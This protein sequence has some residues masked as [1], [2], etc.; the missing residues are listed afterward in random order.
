[1]G[2]NPT[3]DIKLDHN[4]TFHSRNAL[5]MTE[6]ELRL[7]VARL[8]RTAWV[9]LNP[10][11]GGLLVPYDGSR[12]WET[13]PSQLILR[14]TE[15]CVVQI[16]PFVLFTIYILFRMKQES[17]ILRLLLK[18][19]SAELE[20]VQ[21]YLANAV[22]LDGLR[23]REISESLTADLTDEMEHA[24]G[25]AHRLKQLGVCPPGSYALLRNQEALQ[26]PEDPTDLRHV[27]LGVLA[28]EREAMETYRELITACGEE[29]PITADLAVRILTDEAGHLCLFEGFLRGL[30]QKTKD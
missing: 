3:V 12:M 23:A 13:S 6:T 25:L 26:P 7:I 16:E 5:L 8:R 1:M 14:T 30:D 20:T 22:W 11:D 28:A 27:V 15:R 29:D 17:P 10:M 21:N 2:H 4:S 19:Y 18:A 9:G 24:R